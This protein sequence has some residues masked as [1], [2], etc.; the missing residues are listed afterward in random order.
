[1]IPLVDLE[2]VRRLK[3]LSPNVE[4]RWRP[5][6]PRE[7]APHVIPREGSPSASTFTPG[8]SASTIFR[9]K[10]ENAR[11]TNAPRRDVGFRGVLAPDKLTIDFQ[12]RYDVNINYQYQIHAY[13]PTEIDDICRR[14]LFSLVYQPLEIQIG[15]KPFNFRIDADAP[16]YETFGL[17]TDET[18]RQYRL[19]FSFTVLDAF[20]LLD[21]AVKTVI[22]QKVHFYEAV[23]NGSPILLETLNLIPEGY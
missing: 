7:K 14:T 3:V 11:L 5:A 8:Q 16:E 18:I 19:T 23:V 1:M 10:I 17:D 21:E 13:K 15:G 22:Y 2:I 4:L 20:W 6:Q 9:P 12:R